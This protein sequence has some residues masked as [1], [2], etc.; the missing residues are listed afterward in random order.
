MAG[1]DPGWEVPEAAQAGPPCHGTCVRASQPALATLPAGESPATGLHALHT[2]QSQQS[3]CLETCN[4]ASGVDS[5]EGMTGR[6][7]FAFWGFVLPAV[8]APAT[9]LHALHTARSQPSVCRHTCVC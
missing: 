3:A 7:L 9:G 5:T 6:D 8:K 4:H 1:T 2:A